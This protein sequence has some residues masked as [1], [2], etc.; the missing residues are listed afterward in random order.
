MIFGVI[1]IY[2]KGNRPSTSRSWAICRRLCVFGTFLDVRNLDFCDTI[3]LIS[4]YD[5]RI[6][7][8]V[9]SVAK[10]NLSIRFEV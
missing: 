3:I 10:I 1:G 2:W 9:F 4:W 5:L 7:D 6:I 8:M